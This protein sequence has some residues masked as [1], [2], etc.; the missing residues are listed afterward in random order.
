MVFEPLQRRRQHP[1]KIT[2]FFY[3][4][5]SSFTWERRGPWFEFGLAQQNIINDVC[6]A[7]HNEGCSFCKTSKNIINNVCFA[8]HADMTNCA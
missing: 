2:N 8:E 5:A 3:L 6:F 7:E 4:A 1:L